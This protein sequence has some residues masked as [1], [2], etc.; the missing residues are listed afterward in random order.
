MR[1][2]SVQRW[3]CCWGF[4]QLQ[5]GESTSWEETPVGSP[6]Y[7][8]LCLSRGP[9]WPYYT[10]AMAWLW[11]PAPVPAKTSPC[12]RCEQTV[13]WL[14]IS[15]IPSEHLE[16]ICTP[17]PSHCFAVQVNRDKILRGCRIKPILDLCLWVDQLLSHED[18]EA[19]MTWDRTWIP[20]LADSGLGCQ[21]FVYVSHN[22]SGG[23][24]AVLAPTI[25]FWTIPIF[26]LC[27]Q[28]Q[29]SWAFPN[30]WLSTACTLA[31][32]QRGPSLS[33]P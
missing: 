14:D 9:A 24:F 16:F 5:Q 20:S 31:H 3:P 7:L 6:C 12:A 21:C 22:A 19:E 13:R 27:T 11:G 33:K 32:W 18:T 30:A 2:P 25:F 23:I 8:A 4:A 26:T 1:W 17:S 28:F 29:C 15:I 10:P